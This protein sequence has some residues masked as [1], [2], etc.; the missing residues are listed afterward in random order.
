M[1]PSIA[2]FEAAS[3]PS[4]GTATLP[5][6]ELMF[7]IPPRAVLIRLASGGS[8]DIYVTGRAGGELRRL[9][10][11]R[12]I[13]TN[14]AWSPNGRE[15]AFTSSRSGTPQL[16]VM[17][18]EGTNVRRIT[19][20]GD[21]NDGAAWHPEGTAIA[22]SY[23]EKRGSRFDIAV[24]DVVTGESRL[25]TEAPGSHESPSF[26]PDGRRIVF[27]SNRTGRRQIW[28]MSASGHDLRQ[29]TFEGDS[30]APAWSNYPK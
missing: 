22:Y 20:A 4:S 12:G 27:E 23:R 8:S 14:P 30:F 24:V 18:A 3:A 29:L 21:Y 6:I 17:D 5:P 2:N 11:S 19:W 15:I 28:V 25:L 16:Y 26:S 7:T 9:T 10:T 1:K 13:D